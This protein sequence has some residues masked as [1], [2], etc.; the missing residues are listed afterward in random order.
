MARPFSI[1]LAAVI[2]LNANLNANE[3]TT[4]QTAKISDATQDKHGFLVHVVQSP[5][6]AGETKIRV[7]MPLT[8]TKKL[9]VI[10]VL[11][12][13]A[14]G[15]NRYGNG[16]L[17]VQRRG[18][19]KRHN[20]IFVAPTFSALPWYADHPTDEK[21]AQ[22][23]Y[24]LKDVLPFVERSYPVID[25][26][27]GRLLLGFSKSG[28]GA[29][30]LLLRHPDV[31]HRAAA[32]DAPLAMQRFGK[33]GNRPIFGTQENF[34]AYRVTDLLRKTE[35]GKHHRLILLGRGNF[36]REHQEIERLHA[37]LPPE[38]RF[39][40]IDRD[41]VKRKHDWHSGWVPEAVKLLLN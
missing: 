35:F 16:L 28:W 29:W 17:E 30:S 24:L 33:Y 36:H 40:L 18:L 12:V 26:P 14:G 20:A 11:P 38:Q 3:P 9:P 19:H 1:L 10:Y 31:F 32:W 15:E 22:E 8:V 27:A 25:Q 23:S 5:R 4:E 41:G 7:L 21:L 2:S 37:A 6:Q 34:E 39:P 13:E